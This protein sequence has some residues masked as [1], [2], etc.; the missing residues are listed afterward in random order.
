LRWIIR[1]DLPATLFAHGEGGV[2]RAADV[3][4]IGHFMTLGSRIDRR[5]GFNKD[6]NT[7]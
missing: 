2:P 1:F 6:S 4:A 7:A 5:F 3:P